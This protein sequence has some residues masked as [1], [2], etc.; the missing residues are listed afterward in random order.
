MCIYTSTNP[1][2]GNYVYIYL[3][4][5][6]LVPYYVGK[7]SGIRAWRKEHNVKVPT[8]NNR[9]VVVE[10]NLT[11][12]GAFAIERQLIRWYGR[13]DLGL[14]PLRNLTDGGEGAT[15]PKSANWKESASRNRKGSGNSFFGKSHSLETHTRWKNDPRRIKQGEE[16]GFYGKH[17]SLEQREKKRQEKLTATRQTCPYCSKIVDPM[18][19][20]RWHGDKCKMRTL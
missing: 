8:D 1:P 5:S 9:I 11:E 2:T 10:Q 18:N 4:K 15:G 16:N 17:H 12:V 14:G 20:A 13:K 3:R 7:G 6:T 19:Y